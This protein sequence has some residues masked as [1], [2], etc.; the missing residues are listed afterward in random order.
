MTELGT[1][2][3]APTVEI[4]GVSLN[5]NGD[6]SSPF[7]NS[8]IRIQ[9]HREENVQ[10]WSFVQVEK[11]KKKDIFGLAFTAGEGSNH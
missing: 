2:G 10:G 7:L 4:P 5:V 8:I 9:E 11:R 6:G 1:L 3:L